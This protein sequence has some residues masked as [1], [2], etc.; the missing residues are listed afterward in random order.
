MSSADRVTPPYAAEI[1]TL[2]EALTEVVE[3]ANVALVAP[4]GTVTVVGT[5]ATATSLLE[6]ATDTA[7]ACAVRNKVTV[8]V[9]ALPAST[10]VGFRL[11]PTS[12]TDGFTVSTV[13]RVRPS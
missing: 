10:F 12:V 1:V 5:V 11:S 7:P 13:E 8:P 6:S 3:I 4:A 9:E 2:V